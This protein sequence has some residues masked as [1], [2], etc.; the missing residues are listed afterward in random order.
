MFIVA[1]QNYCRH[2]NIILWPTKRNILPV[3]TTRM[4]SVLVNVSVT[5][6]D[7]KGTVRLSIFISGHVTTV[8]KAIRKGGIFQT[9]EAAKSVLFL[10]LTKALSRPSSL[11]HTPTSASALASTALA[12]AHTAFR[13]DLFYEGVSSSFHASLAG[14]RL[15]HIF[16]TPHIA[17]GPHS[18]FRSSPAEAGM[19]SSLARASIPTY[20]PRSLTRGAPADAAKGNVTFFAAGLISSF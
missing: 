17:T 12:A 7:G 14:F 15:V 11:R 1:A 16:V 2:K 13:E 6:E 10:L 20:V 8:L 3:C 19:A 5:A 9:L 18:Y 4:T